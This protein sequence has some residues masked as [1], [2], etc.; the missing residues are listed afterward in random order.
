MRDR[1]VATGLRGVALVAVVYAYFL[2]FAQFAFLRRMADLGFAFWEC[3]RF[4]L[5]LSSLAALLTL[6]PLQP[7]SETLV[8]ALIGA[9]L[10]VTTVT[11]V[12]HLRM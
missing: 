7:P 12:T 1:G 5:G 10:G 8:A 6:G 3:H 11:L 2:I 9:G 4:G